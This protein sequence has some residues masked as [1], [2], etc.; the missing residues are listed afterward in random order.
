MRPARDHRFHV[1]TR[2]EIEAR[3]VLLIEKED[4]RAE[5]A[6][7]ASEFTTYDDPEIYPEVDDP[8]VWKALTQL[9][10]ADLQTSPSEFLHCQDDF[11]AWL[12]EL[13]QATLHAK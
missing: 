3:L 2:S 6:D 1:P 12:V 4:T 8:A 5:V 7:W 9:A 13:R 10:G 11:R